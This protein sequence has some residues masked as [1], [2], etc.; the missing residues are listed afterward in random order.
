MES[1]YEAKG[2]SYCHYGEISAY[3]QGSLSPLMRPKNDE[4]QNRCCPY[5]GVWHHAVSENTGF[6]E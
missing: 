4:A 2:D 3:F 5:L 6:N 1:I